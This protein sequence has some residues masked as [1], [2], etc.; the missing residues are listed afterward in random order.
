MGFDFARSIAGQ[1]REGQN[2]R[3]K[4]KELL[5]NIIHEN[6]SLNKN[7]AYEEM[8]GA[9]REANADYAKYNV[10]VYFRRQQ[11]AY[12][13]EGKDYSA[14]VRYKDGAGSRLISDLSEVT[15]DVVQSVSTHPDCFI[16]AHVRTENGFVRDVYDGAHPE[17]VR[18]EENGK[19]SV[20]S[21]YNIENAPVH[22]EVEVDMGPKIIDKREVSLLNVPLAGME[23]GV[24]PPYD[25]NE[26]H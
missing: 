26:Y 19:K 7:P 2:Q 25:E 21:I 1:F 12:R 4:E 13:V 14:S 3:R 22:G 17:E 23:D 20:Y 11:S 8:S 5:N 10:G 9:W 15:S 16:E 24:T 6:D 18:H